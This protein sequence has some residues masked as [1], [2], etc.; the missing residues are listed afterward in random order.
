[1]EGLKC[2]DFEACRTKTSAME[3][4]NKKYTVV[5]FSIFEY[6]EELSLFEFVENSASKACRPNVVYINPSSEKYL[7]LGTYEYPF[8]RLTD[9]QYE[10]FNNFY[11]LEVDDVLQV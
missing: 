11:L 2:I 3:N 7:E 1:L 10:V 6:D 5:N 4:F 8:K 9:A